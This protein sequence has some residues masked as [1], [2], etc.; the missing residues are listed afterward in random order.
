MNSSET[1]LHMR[2]RKD[3]METRRRLLEAALEVFGEQGF[4]DATHAEICALAGVNISSINY[5]FHSKE[6]LY[7]ATW[8]HA[9]KAID[10]LYPLDGGLGPE[11]DPADRLR[12]QVRAMLNRAMDPRFGRIHDIRM[13]EM[14]NPTG[15]LRESF[16]RRL[17][18]NRAITLG[19]LRDFLGPRATCEDLEFCEMSIVSPCL[20]VHRLAP[21]SGKKQGSGHPPLPW[22]FTAATTER[23]AEH[24]SEFCLAGLVAVRRRI[25]GCS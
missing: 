17:E 18:A 9:V 11:A 25:E 8:E 5:H 2:M 20:V 4:H 15:I 19:Y 22:R 23:L 10:A 24:I 3:G 12:A 7:R 21:A 1:G 6:G 13:M 14:T 16:V